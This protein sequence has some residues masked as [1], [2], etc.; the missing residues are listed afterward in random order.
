MFDILKKLCLAHGVSGNEKEICD[1]VRNIIFPY[2][3]VFAVFGNKDAEKTILLDAHIDQI[4][5]VVTN[6]NSKGFLKVEKCGGIDLRTVQG[7]GVKIY[8]KKVIKGVVCCLP[9]HLTDGKDD[10]AIG[11]EKV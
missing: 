4:G 10:K 11:I 6:I 5:F 8:G 3:N 7:C 9:P 1:T 2:G